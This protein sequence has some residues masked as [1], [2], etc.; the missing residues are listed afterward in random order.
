MTAP[1]RG[2]GPSPR[3]VVIGGGL[4][5]LA[6]AYRLACESSCGPIAD[7]VVLEASERLG[8]KLR[9]SPAEGFVIEAGAD[10]FAPGSGLVEALAAQLGIGDRLVPT[11]PFR[12]RAYLRTD[13][14]F[15]PLLS[16]GSSP[17]SRPRSLL[18]DPRLSWRARARMRI[19]PLMPRRDPV[20][21][22]S[23]ASFLSRRLGRR[24]YV[25]AF[26]PLLAGVYGA[27]PAELS[28]AATVPH[29]VAAEAEGRSLLSVGR[30][31]ASL[32]RSRTPA[33]LS[34]RDGM[35]ALPMAL[36]EALG[37]ARIRRGAE[38]VDVRR[39]T[40]GWSVVTAAG[41]TERADAVVLALPAHAAAA[42]MDAFPDVAGRLTALRTSFTAVVNLGYVT[43]SVGRA[44]DAHGYLN[45]RA[46]GRPV[47]A[48]TYSSAKFEGRAP[49]GHVLLRGFVR[50]TDVPPPGPDR[51]R[52]L[53][54]LVREE[55]HR[56]LAVHDPPLWS[57]VDVWRVP[58]YEVG[59]PERIAVL[60]RA[61]GFRPGLSVVGASYDGVGIAAVIRSADRAAERVRRL[62]QS[63][64]RE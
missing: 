21:D 5:G 12:V 41:E 54:A 46:V 17:I 14:E 56:S 13:G 52:R 28:A 48:I 6:T 33:L 18:G 4:A 50:G 57:Q 30:A 38:V 24:A 1:V 23:L 16:E 32:G 63:N 22:E 51:E 3:V 39:T 34:F 40:S 35:S 60:R 61:I 15:A 37:A 44:L 31:D 11:R 59:H 29:L 36:A 2:T 45:R 19:E 42:L 9:T 43:A 47:S 53:V 20:G 27:E 26:E 58:V 64:G 55:L 49:P 25:E 10:G 62:F 7:V 8:G